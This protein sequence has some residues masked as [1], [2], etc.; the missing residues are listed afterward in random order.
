MSELAALVAVY[1]VHW[2]ISSRAP[3]GSV[4]QPSYTLPPP[5]TIVGAFAQ[6]AYQLKMI[7]GGELVEESGTVASG[8]VRFIEE[9][10]VRWATAAWMSPT[11]R[12]GIPIAYFAAP[13]RATHDAINTVLVKRQ[14]PRNLFSLY[15]VGYIVAPHASIALMLIAEKAS[16]GR[17]LELS[18]HVSRLGSK[19]SFIDPVY[20]ATFQLEVEDRKRPVPV[21]WLTPSMC[22]ESEPYGNYSLEKTPTP[23]TRDEWLCW[24]SASPCPKGSRLK[25]LREAYHPRYP[26]WVKLRPHTRSCTIVRLGKRLQELPLS[27]TI[28]PTLPVELHGL[29]VPRQVIEG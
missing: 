23:M 24:Y 11:V 17:L 20:A 4:V 8:A 13:Y 27:K 1:R 3:W 25:L 28:S 29:I 22:T 6:A 18:A 10:N 15:E 21:P 5:T 2:G 12:T 16:S 26:G 14:P 19:E 7:R 9:F